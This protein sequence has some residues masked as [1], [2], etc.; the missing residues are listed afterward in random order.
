[1]IMRYFL[2]KDRFQDRVL[3]IRKRFSAVSS[4]ILMV[5]LLFAPD[6]L[7]A[8]DVEINETNFP[9]PAFR[10]CIDSLATIR[11]GCPRLQ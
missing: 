6:Q 8:D 3:N 9:D 5:I 7:F 10:K 1:M 2:Q 11:G 4:A